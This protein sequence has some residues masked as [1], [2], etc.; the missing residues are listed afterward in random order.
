MRV[1]VALLSLA[2]SGCV[3]WDQREACVNMGT[4]TCFEGTVTQCIDITADAEDEEDDGSIAPDCGGTWE[5]GSCASQGYSTPCDGYFVRP[6][7]AC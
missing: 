7:S 3:C 2:A 1:L 5:S 6:G 4:A